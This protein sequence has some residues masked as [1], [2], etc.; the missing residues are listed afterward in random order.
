MGCRLEKA[1]H[2]ELDIPILLNRIKR[3]VRLHA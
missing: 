3:D 2:K 1:F